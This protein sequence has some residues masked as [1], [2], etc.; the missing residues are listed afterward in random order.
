MTGPIAMLADSHENIVSMFMSPED[1][2]IAD[3]KEEARLAQEKMLDEQGAKIDAYFES[4]GSP[5]EGYG[6]KMAEEALANDIDFRLL[7]AIAMREST[8][9][10]NACDKFPEN[11]YGWGSCKIGLGG[12][13]DIAIEKMSA[14]LGGN[15][16]NTEKHYAGKTVKKIL[17]TYNPD[18]VI[19]GYSKTG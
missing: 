11:K 12:T 14:H 2:A 17:Q 5:L 3:A 18:S 15:N 10:I 16:P 6:R 13:D 9:G 8:G 4:H 1:R 7:P 19:Q